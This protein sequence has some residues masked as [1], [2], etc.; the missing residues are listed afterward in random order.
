MEINRNKLAHQTITDSLLGKI[1]ARSTTSYIALLCT[2]TNLAPHERFL[3]FP[4]KSSCQSSIPLCLPIG[5]S[6]FVKR[7]N[8][9]YKFDNNAYV[10]YQIR[11]RGRV[12]TTYVAPTGSLGSKTN[13]WA[14]DDYTINEE[15]ETQSGTEE[16][17]IINRENIKLHQQYKDHVPTVENDVEGE[18]TEENQSSRLNRVRRPPPYLD[19]YYQWGRM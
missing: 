11:H 19:R 10:Q 14:T 17:S 16:D 8:Q 12:S 18:V 13:N 1:V 5:T 2:A 6:V 9:G 7:H 15:P 3:G 4:R